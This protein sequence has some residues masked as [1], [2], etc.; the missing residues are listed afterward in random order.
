M[1]LTIALYRDFHEQK[2]LINE[3][4]IAA[5]ILVKIEIVI[6]EPFQLFYFFNKIFLDALITIR[7][8]RFYFIDGIIVN[9]F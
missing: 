4:I 3:R 1:Y 6:K 7:S 5:V 9:K 8:S 2:L